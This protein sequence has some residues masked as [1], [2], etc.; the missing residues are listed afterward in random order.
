MPL[1]MVD[2]NCHCSLL[3][4]HAGLHYMAMAIR[5][6]I[7]TTGLLGDTGAGARII[8]VDWED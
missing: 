8:V 7:S 4:N 1:A 2:V 6:S 5:Y 3:Q